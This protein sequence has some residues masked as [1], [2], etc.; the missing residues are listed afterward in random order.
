[1]HFQALS[2]RIELADD[3]LGEEVDEVESEEAGDAVFEQQPNPQRFLLRGSAG[4][5]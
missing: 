3:A 5:Y 2:H 4:D 1:M